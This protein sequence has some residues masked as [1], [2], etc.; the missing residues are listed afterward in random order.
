MERSMFGGPAFAIHRT[1]GRTGRRT[2]VFSLRMLRR[3]TSLSLFPLP[4]AGVAAFPAGARSYCSRSW[5]FSCGVYRSAPASLSKGARREEK[6]P[7]FIRSP[8]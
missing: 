4:P 2:D 8:I 1:A 6:T 3:K 5:R 7:L